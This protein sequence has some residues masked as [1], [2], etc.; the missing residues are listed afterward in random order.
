[1]VAFERWGSVAREGVTLWAPGSREGQ[2]QEE[3]QEGQE[4]T[5]AG[6]SL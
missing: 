1:M 6:E 3:L 2:C 4:L 5:S